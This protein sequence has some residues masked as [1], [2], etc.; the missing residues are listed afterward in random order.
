MYMEQLK[1]FE[2]ERADFIWK[3]HKTLYGTIQGTHDWTENLNKIFEGHSYYKSS[4][5]P[6][7]YS[8]VMDDKLTITLTWTDDIL[9]ALSILEGESLAKA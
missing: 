9:G 2:E 5:N 3:L 1:E 7:I 8:R 4:T 6:Q